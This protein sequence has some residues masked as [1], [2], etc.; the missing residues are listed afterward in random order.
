MHRPFGD[1]TL[2]RFLSDPGEA[3]RCFTLTD[4]EKAISCARRTKLLSRVACIAA[5]QSTEGQLPA[6]VRDHLDSAR[7]IAESNKRSVFWEVR[8]IRKA[9]ASEGVTFILLKGAAYIVGDFSPAPGRL[10]S[11]ID[12]M[13][14]R[15]HLLQAERA[16]FKHGWLSTKMNA[17]DQ[18]YYRQWMH[19]LPPM[20]H[21]D[22]G[23]SLDVHHTI[24]PPTTHNTLDA[25]K[26][27]H[28]AVEIKGADGVFVLGHA[29]IVLHSA[30][31]LFHEGEWGSGL[32]DLV[33]LHALLGE[34]SKN[35]EF[36]GVLSDRAIELDLGRSLYY[37][38]RYCQMVLGTHVPEVVF[39]RISEAAAP[40]KATLLVMDSL[41][42]NAIGTLLENRTSMQSSIAEFAL[43]VRSH[44]LRMPLYLLV[45]HLV[46]KQFQFVSS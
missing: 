34:F 1:N 26:L 40:G 4:W 2:L 6:K 42:V 5:E 29:D 24:L 8:Q 20:Q 3:V 43:Y 16:L 13:V 38:A 31:H 15:D 37:A 10:L 45:P 7:C 18:R 11:D 46:R 14:S 12:I 22:R 25:G 23:T 33:D 44:Y 39:A 21:L 35:K 9:L 19:E 28:Q 30:A 27:W 32:R 41:V 36:W 17:Y